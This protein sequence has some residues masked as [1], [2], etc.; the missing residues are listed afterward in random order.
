MPS[1]APRSSIVRAIVRGQDAR[2]AHYVGRVKIGNVTYACEVF[3]GGDK[4]EQHA[5]GSGF[6]H[7]QRIT[8]KIRKE[9]LKTAPPRGTALLIDGTKFTL[10]DVAGQSAHEPAWI[11]H[12]YR[13]P[14]A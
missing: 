8:C 6:A 4:I 10:E 11:I 13:L 2:D 14:P 7:V 5:D 12:A 9:L 1:H 3:I